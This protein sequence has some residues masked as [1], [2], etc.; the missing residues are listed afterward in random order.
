M[1]ERI[2]EDEAAHRSVPQVRLPWNGDDDNADTNEEARVRDRR[3]F[4][5]FDNATIMGLQAT[6]ED[7]AKTSG[8]VKDD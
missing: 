4:P 5:L 7:M 1:W 3:T 8:R 2:D 6:I